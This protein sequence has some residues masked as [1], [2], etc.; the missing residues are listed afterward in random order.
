MI[1]E[2]AFEI[3]CKYRELFAPYCDRIEIAGSI[4]R[5]KP[6]PKDIELVAIPQMQ[7]VQALF[8]KSGIKVSGLSIPLKQLRQNEKFRFIKAGL[9]YIQIVLP[10]EIVLDLFIVLPPAQWGVE[11]L[12]RTG[13]LEFN[14]WLV[15]HRSK[16]GALPA[17][18]EMHDAGI[19][20]ARKLVEMPE[21]IDLLNF[22]G[23]GWLEPAE[24]S[25][26]WGRITFAEVP[27]NASVTAL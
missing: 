22:L 12:L 10:E 1:H 15:T 24:R 8:G 23:L 27:K 6:W 18:A 13:P 17:F 5:G 25:P 16:G 11:Y 9:R 3:A 4:R 14:T 7:E 2:K 26:Q 21:E 19:Y 20:V